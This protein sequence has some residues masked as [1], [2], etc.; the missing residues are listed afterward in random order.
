MEDRSCLLMKT[1]DCEKW[2]SEYNIIVGVFSLRVA[3]TGVCSVK[4]TTETSKAT[5]NALFLLCT[6]LFLL[7]YI[8]GSTLRA[9]NLLNQGD[10]CLLVTYRRSLAQLTSQLHTGGHYLN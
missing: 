3:L 5:D 4:A 2:S 10:R 1:R 9:L 7:L 6:C 8:R